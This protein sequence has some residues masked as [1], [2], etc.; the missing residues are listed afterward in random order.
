MAQHINITSDLGAFYLPWFE[1]DGDAFKEAPDY[2]ASGLEIQ[3][4]VGQEV[5]TYSGEDIIEYTYDEVPYDDT[6]IVYQNLGTN[7]YMS[8]IYVHPSIYE[9]LNVGEGES[10]G[11][12]CATADTYSAIA[13]TLGFS[14]GIIVDEQGRVGVGEIADNT[15]REGSILDGAYSQDKFADNFITSNKIAN[16][17]YTSSKFAD[18]FLTSNKLSDNLL[19]ASKIATDALTAAKL[20]QDA[21]DLIQNGLATES[22]QQNIQAEVEETIKLNTD[23]TLET[24][25]GTMDYIK[26]SETET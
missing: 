23:L 9:N 1:K 15:I 25:E 13:A 19:T 16:N 14:K 7:I 8:I 24:P 2:N 11:M 26:W 21:I 12:I 17:A 10:I 4:L 20:A 18:N 22:T 5:Y 6:E 3:I